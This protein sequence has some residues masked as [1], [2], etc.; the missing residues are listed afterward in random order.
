MFYKIK[1]IYY[2]IRYGM[3][4][5]AALKQGSKV[6]SGKTHADCFRQ[7]P[8]GVLRDA[9]QGFVTSTNKF[10]DRKTALKIA[11]HYNQI[12]HKHMP[13]DEL[14]SEDIL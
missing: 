13:E 4:M 11:K 5:S 9:K 7:E 1:S 6:Y 10:V 8:K 3:I 2:N 14:L 12:K